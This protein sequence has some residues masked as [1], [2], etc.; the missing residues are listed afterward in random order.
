MSSAGIDGWRGASPVG[1]RGRL[2]RFT[3]IAI[4]AGVFSLFP[5]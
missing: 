1:C 5:R 3:R 2:W 4:L